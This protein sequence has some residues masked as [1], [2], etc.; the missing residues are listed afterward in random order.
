[1]IQYLDHFYEHWSEKQPCALLLDC[2]KA[3]CTAAVKK[4]AKDHFIELIFVPANGTSEYQPLDRRIILCTF[5]RSCPSLL[6]GSFVADHYLMLRSSILRSFPAL[7]QVMNRLVTC[8]FTRS[9]RYSAP[10]CQ[11]LSDAEVIYS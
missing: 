4:F 1:M 6:A 5:T 11:Q 7:L 9:C 10:G 2:F 8:T 3:H